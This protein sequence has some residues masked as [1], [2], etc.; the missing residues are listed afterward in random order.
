MEPSKE[1]SLLDYARYYGIASNFTAINPARLVEEACAT[2]TPLPQDVVSEFTDQLHDAQKCLDDDISHEKLDIR[3]D[4]ASFLFSVRR[5]VQAQNID[6]P[7]HAILPPFTSIDDIK[8]D[9]PLLATIDKDTDFLSTP[10]LRYQ[11]DEIEIQPLQLLSKAPDVAA[12]DGVTEDFDQL[13]EDIKFEKLD[14]SKKAFLVLQDMKKYRERPLK[15]MDALFQNLTI[16]TQ[17]DKISEHLCHLLRLPVT[18]IDSEE[19]LDIGHD[20]TAEGVAEV[21]TTRKVSGH[22]VNDMGTYP[23][24]VEELSS[25][26]N[27]SS[28]IDLSRIARA[29]LK[30]MSEFFTCTP[31]DS[32]TSMSNEPLSSAPNA[33]ITIT[34]PL[35]D[36]IQ[37]IYRDYETRQQ[38]DAKGSLQRHTFQ[39][40]PKEADIII[41]PTTG[42][43]LTTS[44]ATT[45]LYLPGHEPADPL[46]PKVESIN[47]PLRERIYLLAFR[48]EYLY[49]FVCYQVVSPQNSQDKFSGLTAD[50]RNLGSFTLLNAFCNSI[51][52]YS[53]VTPL[54]IP[55]SPETISGWVLYLTQRHPS[56]FPLS[57][58]DTMLFTRKDHSPQTETQLQCLEKET[59]WEHFLRRAGLNPYAAQV[60][61]LALREIQPKCHH[62]TPPRNNQIRGALSKFIEMGPTERRHYFS[63]LV[64]ERVLQR[65]NR[66]VERDWQCDWALEFD[67]HYDER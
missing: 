2:A 42:I 1:P 12:P 41:S 29:T 10:P 37:Q 57:T 27:P 33:T 14:C 30:E 26:N 31:E 16:M 23:I 28:I 17:Q 64:G 35:I 66:L 39:K 59:L 54:A 44:Q 48:Y 4:C 38:N 7:W 15:E 8:L 22:Q 3:M 46:I 24:S 53:S 18:N 6:I 11:Q 43:V 49:V 25:S 60:I 40:L 56:K 63:D 65:V 9:V 19:L 61:L 34:S 45:Q 58:P 62:D 50:K 47:S 20:T 51:S 21:D 52:T 67:D 36:P 13:M 32:T 5:D 55:A